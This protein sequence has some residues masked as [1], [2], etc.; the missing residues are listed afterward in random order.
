MFR[1]KYLS[2]VLFAA[3]LAGVVVACSDDDD[4]IDYKAE[5][6]KAGKEICDCMS[7]YA[8]LAP[9]IEDYYSETGFDQP[10]YVEA[11]TAYGWQASGC[12]GGLQSYQEY[13]TVNFEAYNAEAEN[14]LLSVFDFKNNDFKTGFSEGIGSCADAF[15]ELLGLMGQM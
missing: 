11:L 8:H 5:G 12:V 6:V 4:K 9:N 1:F 13:V 10:G 2:V 3:I 15:G 7:S 14:P